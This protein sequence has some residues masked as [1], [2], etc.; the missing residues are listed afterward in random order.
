MLRAERLTKLDIVEGIPSRE[1]DDPPE[2]VD[3]RIPA[4]VEEF[5][6]TLESE[7]D[8]TAIVQRF[9]LHG[10]SYAVNGLFVIQSALTSWWRA[11]LCSSERQR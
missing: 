3:P 7:L 6:L 11:P 8:D 1:F 4:L 10:Q 9:L 2:E 5:Q